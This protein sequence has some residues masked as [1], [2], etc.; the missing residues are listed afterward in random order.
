MVKG[1][2]LEIRA[3]RECRLGGREIPTRFRISEFNRFRACGIKEMYEVEKQA[4]QEKKQN[5]KIITN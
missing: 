4:S 3:G 5:K 2:G 1:S